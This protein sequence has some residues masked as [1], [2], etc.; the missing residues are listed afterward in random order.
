MY[1]SNNPI[2]NYK[3]IYIEIGRDIVKDFDRV[4]VAIIHVPTKL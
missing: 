4:L 1:I 2:Q 3:S